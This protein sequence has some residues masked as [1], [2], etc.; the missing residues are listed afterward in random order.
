[1]KTTFNKVKN[2]RDFNDASVRYALPNTKVPYVPLISSNGF[3]VKKDRSYH[4]A[5]ANSTTFRSANITEGTIKP[6]TGFTV[7]KDANFQDV[8]V[9]I[10][11]G[12]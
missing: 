5:T 10:D 1:M 6:Y 8:F 4:T 3:V 2:N 12:L 7:K 9:V 11:Q